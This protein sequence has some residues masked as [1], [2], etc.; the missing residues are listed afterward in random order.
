MRVFAGEY[1]A[2]NSA[3]EEVYGVLRHG[4]ADVIEPDR[5]NDS[6]HDRKNYDDDDDEGDVWRILDVIRSGSVQPSPRC[7]AVTNWT[8]SMRGRRPATVLRTLRLRSRRR[9]GAV[10]AEMMIAGRCFT[11]SPAELRWLVRRL[12]TAGY[13]CSAGPPSA[14]H[15]RPVQPAAS[16]RASTPPPP[17]SAETLTNVHARDKRAVPEDGGSRARTNAV[18][19]SSENSCMYSADF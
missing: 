7:S 18:Q 10:D 12:R 1:V 3:L 16:A 6:K 14:R 19:D 8:D 13:R 2:A 4:Y 5:R 9:P 11:A 17:P 15:R